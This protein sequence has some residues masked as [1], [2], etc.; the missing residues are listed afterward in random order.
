[1]SEPMRAAFDIFFWTAFA[2]LMIVAADFIDRAITDTFRNPMS[3][4]VYKPRPISGEL[5]G[6]YGRHASDKGRQDLTHFLDMWTC[7]TE[8]QK[9]WYCQ[10]FMT[11]RTSV[12]PY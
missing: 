2:V 6:G 1:M 10:N 12:L 8:E 11:D 3:T 5:Y 9:D 7:L 4:E